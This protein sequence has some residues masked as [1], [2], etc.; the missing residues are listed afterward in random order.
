MEFHAAG[1]CQN[2]VA[3]SER[4]AGMPCRFIF[5]HSI[6]ADAKSGVQALLGA[7]PLPMSKLEALKRARDFESVQW[8]VANEALDPH[9]VGLAIK[10]TSQR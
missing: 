8:D 6:S 5:V 10:K 7:E 4:N 3:G 1:W 2:Y 9:V